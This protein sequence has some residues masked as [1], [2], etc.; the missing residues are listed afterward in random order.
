MLFAH[1][2]ENM[3]KTLGG[4]QHEFQNLQRVNREQKHEKRRL[5]D[6][7]VK[8]RMARTGTNHRTTWI[9][10]SATIADACSCFGLDADSVVVFDGAEVSC[11]LALAKPNFLYFGSGEAKFPFLWRKR[12]KKARFPVLW[13]WRSK[14]NQ[15]FLYFCAGEA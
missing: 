7:V 6:E 14:K 2:V 13:H 9:P 8:V 15:C 11:T 12:S 1:R 4:L 5:I 10:K 3:R